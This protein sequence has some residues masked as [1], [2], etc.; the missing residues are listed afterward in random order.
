MVAEKKKV[1][2]VEDHPLMVEGLTM[3]INRT[4]DMQVCGSAE[5]LSDA[6]RRIESLTPDVLILDLNLKHE[7]SG[8]GGITRL[9]EMFPKLP[10]IVHS[11]HN[12]Y[13]YVERSLNAGAKGYV[14]K[15]EG[16]DAIINAIRKALNN[17]TYLDPDTAS[18]IV[19]RLFQGQTETQRDPVQSL[20][21][22]ELEIYEMIGKGKSTR[23]IAQELVL[24][25]STVETHRANIKSKLKLHSNSQLVKSAVEWTLR[26][27]RGV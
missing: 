5:S 23:E 6:V 26:G 19:D 18:K 15:R 1:L 10:I 24:S 22:R 25:V 14:N 16:N 4:P 13:T 11:M 9:R 3:A 20:S 2:I 8:L 12:E 21:N 27:D 17:E 7:E